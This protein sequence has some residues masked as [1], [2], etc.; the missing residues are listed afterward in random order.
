[1]IG[2][3]IA[4]YRIIEKL[5]QGGMGVVY[6]AEDTKLGR[7][8]A[9]KFP[10][11]RS[12]QS[13]E[14]FQRLVHEARA[15][16]SLDHQNI[17]TIHEIGEAEGQ[18]YIAMSFV[19]GKTLRDRLADG[20][21][22]I[23]ETVGI[24]AQV[25]DGLS[26]AHE[27]GI[28]HRDIKPENIMINTRGQVKIMDFGLAKSSRQTT[29]ITQEGSTPGTA[30]YMSP[31]QAKGDGVDARSDLWSLGVV[32]YEAITGK[33]PFEGSHPAAMMYAVLHEPHTSVS[34]HR[35]DV[36]A[37]LVSLIDRL[38]RKD[39]VQRPVG[40]KLVA[41]ELAQ[42]R[43]MLSGKVSSKPGVRESAQP[44]LAVL[45]FAN[46]STDAENEFFADG[47]TED[48]IT[49]FSKMKELR[50]VAR[51]SAFQFKG[52]TS[53]VRLIGEQLNVGT[54]LEGSVRKS[55]NRL[56]VTAQLINVA[57]GF[58]IWSERY[59]REMAD[60]FEIQDDI[61]RAIVEA[62]K[63]KLVAGRNEPL[64]QAG[65]SQLEAYHLVLQG[66]HHWNRRTNESLVKAE[67]CFLEA[68]R[69]DPEY[70]EAHGALALTYAVMMDHSDNPHAEFKAKLETTAHAALKLKPD[71]WE[72]H[73]ALAMASMDRLD[74]QGAERSIRRAIDA[75]PGSATAHQWYSLILG[76]QGRIAEARAEI[77]LAETLDPLS[78]IILT[79]A[80]WPR[81]YA[82]DYDQAMKRVERVRKLDPDFPIL[83][84]A[85]GLILRAMGRFD[86]AGDSFRRLYALVPRPWGL[87]LV[88][89]CDFK[90]GHMDR[91]V[92]SLNQWCESS[93]LP[94]DRTDLQNALATDGCDG[95]QRRITE[96]L[97][98]PLPQ[99][100]TS[101]ANLAE[102]FMYLNNFDAAFAWLDLAI[103]PLNPTARALAVDPLWGPVRSDP[104]FT[105]L[106][107]KLNLPAA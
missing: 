22:T 24:A 9:L 23:A 70:S 19:V 32:M 42:I 64:V 75:N 33:L 7:E 45:P 104:R 52:K 57:D 12:T 83:H 30:A 62:L 53:D 82:G 13:A 65:T 79:S 40:T 61:A 58:H 20:P 29:K 84:L 18:P 96:L 76:Y 100:Q 14:E 103:D 3:T 105:V 88:A 41:A 72:A 48:L 34:G 37:D 102:L 92:E 63:V 91:L 15:A 11:P 107:K 50:V 106:L 80:A 43:D 60:V 27:K 55:G 74:W 73:A 77:D 1:M 39:P 49:A 68:L 94:F 47:L 54:V 28:T 25:A 98:K 8:V 35:R 38:L 71:M 21:I 89:I 2:Q 81:Y 85:E 87:L 66:R 101:A 16:A 44:S 99:V 59:D 36:P 78:L 95:L 90:S 93:A 6:K 46:M 10:P 97:G 69:L 4:H 86:E 67:A 31:E 26:V 51:T 5:G 17:C 56:R